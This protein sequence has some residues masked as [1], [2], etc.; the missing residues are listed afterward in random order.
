MG[1]W[2]YETFA[3]D[4][5]CDWLSELLESKNPLL[6]LDESLSIEDI[7]Y[8]EYDNGCRIIGACEALYSIKHSLRETTKEE[9]IEWVN[10][11]KDL[12][13]NSLLLKAIDSAT[14]VLSDRSEL[15][16]LWSENEEDYP[17]WVK[18]IELLVEGL[19]M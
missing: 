1:A 12:D 13:I 4:I 15:K 10:N 3:D 11:N 2:G 19:K 14:F 5:T 8:I 16:E 9:F 7:D 18:N 17:K 6:F